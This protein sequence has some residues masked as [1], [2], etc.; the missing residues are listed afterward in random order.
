MFVRKILRLTAASSLR[1]PHATVVDSKFVQRWYLENLGNSPMYVPYGANID[2]TE[3]DENVLAEAVASRCEG[4]P[5]DGVL[6][7]EPDENR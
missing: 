3:P 5:P 2:L 4:R 7:F 1:L 6:G